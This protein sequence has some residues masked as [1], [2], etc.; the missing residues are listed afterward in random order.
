M[1]VGASKEAAKEEVM[2]I[3]EENVQRL[4][5]LSE[6]ERKKERENIVQQL[7]KKY[8]IVKFCHN[9]LVSTDPNLLSFLKSRHL[10]KQPLQPSTGDH[11]TMDHTPK[12]PVLADT[13]SDMTTPT[14]WV[15]MDV[16]ERDKMEWMTDVPSHGTAP[17]VR[18]SNEIRFSLEG[19]VI[20]RSIVIPAHLGL[21]HHGDE[22][23]V[24]LSTHNVF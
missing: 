7:G 2:K 21:H 16:V 3:H 1:S 4:S 15:H 17:L 11:M 10:Q 20:P 12:P 6:E 22:P 23:Q 5:S 13:A 8:K 24:E 9:K 18:S 19:L 14:S